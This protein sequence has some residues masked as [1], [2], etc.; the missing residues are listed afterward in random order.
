VVL[1]STKALDIADLQYAEERR[2][3]G[4]GFDKTTTTLSV[5]L[6]SFCCRLNTQD[7]ISSRNQQVPPMHPEL[8]S[9]I[10]Q[11]VRRYHYT[12]VA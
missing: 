4:V 12:D 9:S 6:A 10:D 1:K 8:R 2:R 7:L 5:F 3:V 11:A